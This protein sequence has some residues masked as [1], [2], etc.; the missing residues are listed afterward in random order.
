[1][2]DYINITHF[3]HTTSLVKLSHTWKLQ[4][5]HCEYYQNTSWNR[6]C[7]ISSLILSRNCNSTF[8]PCSALPLVAVPFRS[9][10]FWDPERY[11]TEWKICRLSSEPKHDHTSDGG[12]QCAV[13]GV[14]MAAGWRGILALPS[15]YVLPDW[16]GLLQ[17][18]GQLYHGGLYHAL[19][20]DGPK[21]TQYRLALCNGGWGM[22]WTPR[23]AFWAIR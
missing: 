20:Q 23:L 12:S 15:R 3:F 11:K 16:D 8:D 1:M 18:R 14:G 2:W 4:S 13:C 6:H 19:R 22:F 5:N 10:P 21:E 7:H 17:R 9:V